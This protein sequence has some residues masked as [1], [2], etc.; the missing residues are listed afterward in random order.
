MQSLFRHSLI[1]EHPQKLTEVKENKMKKYTEP[2]AVLIKT[3]DVDILTG[4][5]NGIELPEIPIGGGSGDSGIELPEIP[6]GKLP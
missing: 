4:S 2:K 6:V 3:D 5:S 1:T